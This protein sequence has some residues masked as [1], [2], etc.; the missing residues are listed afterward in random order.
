MFILKFI[1][2]LLLVFFLLGRVGWF[3]LKTLIR[4]VPGSRSY[5][6]RQ[7]RQQ[8]R[9]GDIHIDYIP[10]SEIK[11]RRKAKEQGGD[12]VDFEELK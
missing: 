12:Y 2:I 4:G 9:S 8:Q 7:Q 3:I 6:E 11:R 10:E 5:T 1:F